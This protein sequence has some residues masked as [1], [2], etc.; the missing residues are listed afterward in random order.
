MKSK[1]F[2]KSLWIWHTDTVME[3]DYGEFLCEF[4]SDGSAVCRLSCHHDYALFLNGKH[5]DNGQFA[6]FD[7]FK[8]YDTLDLSEHTVKGKNVLAIRVWYC[9][10]DTLRF[11]DHA[12]GLIF[13]VTDKDGTILAVSDGNVLA[14]RSRAYECGKKKLITAQLGPT[15][16]YNSTLENG[17]KNGEVNGFAKAVAEGTDRFSFLPRPNKKH[18]LYPRAESK[19]IKVSEDKKYYLIDLGKET[20]GLFDVEFDSKETNPI[21]FT[22]GEH[23]VDGGV[24]RIIGKRDFSF[25]YVASAGHN[26]FM[27]H[28]LRLGCRYIELHSESPVELTYMGVRPQVYP[29]NEKPFKLENE[30]DERIYRLSLDTLKLCMMEHYVDCPWREQGLYALDSRN[31]MLCGYDAFEN[32]NCEYVRANLLLMSQDRRKDGLLSMCFPS[33]NKL[34]IPSFALH[35]FMSVREYTEHSGDLTLAEELYPK[36]VSVMKAFI[37]NMKD[38]LILTFTG[39]NHWNFYDWTDDL[40]GKLWTDTEAVHDMTLNSLAI[41]ALD[42]LKVISDKIGKPFPYDGIADSLRARCRQTFFNP[43]KML[44]SMYAPSVNEIYNVLTNSLAIIADVIDDE[45]AKTVCENMLSGEY[46]DCTLSLKLVKYTAML[47]ADEKKYRDVILNDIRKEYAYMLDCGATAAWETIDG[48]AAFHD[49]GSLCH[50]WSAVP[51][52]FYHR[53][54]MV[55]TKG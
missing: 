5:I 6:D 14:R 29:V 50:G 45:T 44:F 1:V 7:H 10:A 4:E 41:L 49:A 46:I 43:E 42:S 52:H 55:N 11:T 13:E 37:D 53:F 9:S 24:R 40:K 35:Y 30:L 18:L 36:L 32:G 19:I 31:Q 15:F 34:T 16:F 23:I 3:D 17:W 27:S 21:M 2:D 28:T 22:Y 12:P 48:A 33:A 51:I 20:V 38:G 8:T 25:Y 39:K 54:G 47:K 26:E